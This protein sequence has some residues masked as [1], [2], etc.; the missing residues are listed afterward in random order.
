MSSVS[1]DQTVVLITG[2]NQGLG[3]ECVKKLASEQSNYIILLGARDPVKGKEA[4]SKITNL[5]SGTSVD[6]LEIDI[7]NDA[8]LA[9]AAKTVEA[10]YGRLDALFNNAG[11]SAVGKP[12]S[13]ECYNAVLA[14][15]V[16]GPAC[17]TEAF[18]P[19]LRK[20]QHPRLLFMS[21]GLASC[22]Q[23]LDPKSPY[24]QLGDG[25]DYKAYIVSKCADN[26]LGVMYAVQLGKEGFKVNLIDP[27]FRATNI[28]G[29][30][31]YGGLASEGAIQA[32]KL[33]V[34]TDKDGPHAT[35]SD[36]DG[37]LPW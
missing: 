6:L 27:G 30:S 11:I 34:N 1:Q 23:M 24:W 9:N 7:N 10:R 2:A 20:A 8:S 31:P 36:M 13:R 19:L 16:T 32:C 12:G 17:A 25:P 26:M 37:I 5:A 29:Y 35:F 21:S 14:T 3:F 15:N 28:N 4:T 18:L 22:T 33:I